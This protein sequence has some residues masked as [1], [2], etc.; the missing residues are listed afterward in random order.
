MTRMQVQDGLSGK[1]YKGIRHA[2]GHI[3][4]QDGILG[5]YRGLSPSLLG[6]GISWGIYFYSYNIGKNM[7]R[8]HLKLSPS[9]HLSV[10]AHLTCA[11]SAGVITTLITNPIWMVKTRF[12][13]QGKGM[14]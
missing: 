9:D 4:R 11:A 1:E 5:L 12:Q 13:L 3:I 6:N 14:T 2:F 8:H 7:M 10:P